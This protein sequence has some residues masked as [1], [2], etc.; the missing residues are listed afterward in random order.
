VGSCG[1]AGVKGD[2]AG[3]PAHEFDHHDLVPGLGSG[4]EAVDGLRGNVHGRVVPEGRV[5]GADVVVDG[6]GDAHHR[7]TR[8]AEQVGCGQRPVAADHDQ[9]VDAQG[10][11]QF[12]RSFHAVEHAAVL[13][14]GRAEDGAAPGEDAAHVVQAERAAPPLDQPEV[15]VQYTDDA[16]TMVDDRPMYD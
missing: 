5:R 13:D 4:L 11:L 16:V 8:R 3:V 9:R 1:H 7:Q 12:V 14:S 10:R 2:P 15:A 6:L